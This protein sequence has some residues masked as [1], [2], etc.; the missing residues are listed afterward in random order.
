MQYTAWFSFVLKIH[1]SSQECPTENFS[2]DLVNIL[3]V[4]LQS[5]GC[6]FWQAG[7]LSA[8]CRSS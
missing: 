8:N 7:C 2:P 4:A 5:I 3:H 1:T 6:S